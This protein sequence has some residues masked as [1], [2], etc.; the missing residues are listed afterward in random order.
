MYNRCG[1]YWAG[2]ASTLLALTCAAFLISD[3][4]ALAAG[5][6]AL[7]AVK[8]RSPL[9]PDAFYALPLTA[10]KPK[11]WL[12]R[13]LE[14]QAHGLTGH[15]DEFWPDVGPNSGWLGG[16]G[17]SWERGPYFADGLVPLAYLLDDPKLIA[18]ARTWME[19]TL[20][21]QRPDGSIGPATN[22]DWWP[23]MVMLKAL[24]QYQEATGD[25]RVIPLMQRYF[26]Y[27]AANLTARP[28]Q[29][30]AKY[31]WADELVSVLWLYNR[32]GDHTL[33]D[34]ARTLQREGHDWKGEFENF[35]FSAKTN[36]EELGLGPG[37]HNNDV[38]MS[39]HGVNNAMALKTSAEWSLVS[40]D[41]S[42]RR[43]A[44]Q[45]LSELEEFHL[46]PNGMFSCD[47][48]LAGHDPSQ[49]TELCSVVEEQFSLEKLISILGQPALGDRLERIS[50]NALPG[51]F[52][53]DMW[54]HQ[55]DQ[56][57]NQVMAT[58]EQRDWTTNGPEANIFGVE[59][60]F[61]CCTA[62]M[63]QGWPKFAASLW[64]AT[65]NDGLAAVAYAPSEVNSVGR[66]GVGVNI[67]E[68]T[69][70]PFRS[71]IRFTVS[72]ARPTVFPLELRIPAWA[73]S[74]KIT[75][76]GG[77][78]ERVRP[79]EFHSIQR[80]WKKG[81]KVVLSLPM[82]IRTSRA[83]HNSVVVER[84]PLVF[85]LRIGEKWRKIDK[86]M[87]KPAASP[88]TDWA[89]EP[90]TPWN[91]G[92]IIN[93][94]HPEQSVEVV[95]KKIGDF[96]FSSDGAPVELRIKGRRVPDWKL[97]DGSAGPLPVSPV[98]SSEGMETLTLIPYGSAKLRITAFPQLAE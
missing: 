84:G 90:T 2:F 71:E 27:Q 14:I 16:T 96:P 28:L 29:Q 41:A 73:E 24:T 31:R 15:L 85:S 1:K 88:A 20:T 32:T 9:R 69:E 92:L 76:N 48:H 8:N 13:Q 64:M 25:P 19:W 68:E 82:Q 30:W 66:N 78:A 87:S 23:N 39:A 77:V 35:P 34:L 11:G 3:S 91:Y 93:R 6:S 97:V 5:Q 67:R 63:H 74:A 89:V 22:K 61:G 75:V 52:S 40:G 56:Q 65:P 54:A 95:E 59:P 70:Y 79:G 33:L 49:G 94:D 86:G 7:A 57:P 17:E 62:N 45:Q 81:D 47:E 80:K 44:S 50:F 38:A 18:K 37:G 51:T 26:R 43:A 72:P 36:K 21:H 53:K 58:L 55:Y 83:Y 98:S 10:I 12:R 60:N 46:L 42:D 4:I